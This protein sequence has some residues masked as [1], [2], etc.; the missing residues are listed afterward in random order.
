MSIIVGLAAKRAVCHSG[1][2]GVNLS[3]VLCQLSLR[4]Q[5]HIKFAV[6]SLDEQKELVLVFRITQL[7]F[8]FVHRVDCF[9]VYFDNDVSFSQTG[10][11]GS[12][13]RLDADNR[14]TVLGFDPELLGYIPIE[15]M[16]L[17]APFSFT[18]VVSSTMK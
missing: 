2:R 12:T 7:L 11:G 4:F 1:G 15:V 8:N 9:A 10:F 6:L 14:H 3:R 13:A 17:Q 16:Q 18:S 5:R